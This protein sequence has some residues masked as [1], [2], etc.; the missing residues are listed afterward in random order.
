MVLE[1]VAYGIAI[2]AAWKPRFLQDWK[3]ALKE[4]ASADNRL[5]NQESLEHLPANLN[6]CRI[7]CAAPSEYWDVC[8]EDRKSEEFKVILRHLSKKGFPVSFARLDFAG[9]LFEP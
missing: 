2:Q 7:L 9:K 4:L 8:I 1:A 5:I 6:T 3:Y